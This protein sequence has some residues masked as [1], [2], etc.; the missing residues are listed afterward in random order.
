[1]VTLPKRLLTAVVTGLTLI[2][3]IGAALALPPTGGSIARVE[4]AWSPT[5]VLNLQV[6]TAFELDMRGVLTTNHTAL[7]IWSNEPCP[8]WSSGG[9]DWPKGMS[10]CGKADGAG[11]CGTPEVAGTY[12]VTFKF[13]YYEASA[14]GNHY[15]CCVQHTWTLVIAPKG[16]A[17]V[18]PTKDEFARIGSARVTLSERLK[19]LARE[20]RPQ[21][22]PLV[23]ERQALDEELPRLRS[24]FEQA[25]AAAAALDGK[26]PPLAVQVERFAAFLRQIEAV[27]RLSPKAVDIQARNSLTR[28]MASC[29]R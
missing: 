4:P 15:V 11:L 21:I 28:A 29:R 26:I 13:Q 23:K 22:E 12:K 6:G 17:P 10:L 24:R 27:E 3:A 8:G 18:A 20:V 19:R 25:S 1:M 7:A 9:C 5:G 2:A 14:P 16:G